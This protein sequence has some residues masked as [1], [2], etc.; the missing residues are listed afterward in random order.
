M[1]RATERQ[2]FSAVVIAASSQSTIS[3]TNPNVE[4]ENPRREFSQGYMQH[5]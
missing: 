4:L 3:T 1:A 2:A 5:S